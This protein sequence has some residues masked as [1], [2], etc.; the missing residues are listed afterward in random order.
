MKKGRHPR[1]PEREPKKQSRLLLGRCVFLHRAFF[2]LQHLDRRHLNLT[3]AGIGRTLQLNVMA[4][5]ALHG[6]G[7]GNGPA[8]AVRVAHERLAILADR[9]LDAGGL[10]RALFHRRIVALASG[11]LRQRNHRQ[12]QKDRK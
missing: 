8:L 3:G 2:T 7:I 5:M 1:R 6:V 4:F 11:I 10:G 9:T 12:R